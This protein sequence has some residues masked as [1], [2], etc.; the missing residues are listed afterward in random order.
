MLRLNFPL[1]LQV[2]SG[3]L[4]GWK[5]CWVLV[6]ETPLKSKNIYAN[7]QSGSG[8]WLVNTPRWWL[9]DAHRRMVNTPWP[10][11][12]RGGVKATFSRKGLFTNDCQQYGFWFHFIMQSFY[13]AS[14]LMK[15]VWEPIA[16][17]N[18]FPCL[19]DR[20]HKTS[21]LLGFGSITVIFSK[22]KCDIWGSKKLSSYYTDPKKTEKSLK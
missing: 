15:L 6:Y 18:S 4:M 19:R 21:Q 22:L 10:L 7:I 1:Q 14:S 13:A 16:L 3:K 9:V 12:N 8:R 5:E 11:N 2:K 17:N 20:L